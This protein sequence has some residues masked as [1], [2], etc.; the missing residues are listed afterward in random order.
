[1]DAISITVIAVA[2]GLLCFPWIAAVAA[3]ALKRESEPDVLADLKVVSRIGAAMSQAG[4]DEAAAAANALIEAVL[5]V[6]A[7]VRA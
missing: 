6:P 1:M 5:R 7:K 2:A 4:N 3:K